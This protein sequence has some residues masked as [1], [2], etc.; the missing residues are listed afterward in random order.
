MFTILFL[1]VWSESPY[2]SFRVIDEL[3]QTYLSHGDCRLLGREF[4]QQ[5]HSGGGGAALLA[6]SSDMRVW[7][8]QFF[9]FLH[10]LFRV[11]TKL[12]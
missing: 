9:C 6:Q 2:L 5:D 10:L 11:L 4:F 8:A 12:K 7:E 3:W 1:S